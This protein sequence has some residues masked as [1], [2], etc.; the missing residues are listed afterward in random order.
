MGALLETFRESTASDDL[1]K[2]L[3]DIFL[4]SPKFSEYLLTLIQ[5]GYITL[6]DNLIETVLSYQGILP[7]SENSSLP[8]P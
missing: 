3:L 1:K 5:V 8:R 4:K 6:P 2:I 7:D